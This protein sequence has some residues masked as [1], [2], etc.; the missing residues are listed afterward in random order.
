[1]AKS[2]LSNATRRG[3]APLE[4]VLWLPVLMFTAALIVN[5]GTA[6]AWR[7]RGETVS[8]NTVW[9]LRWPRTG[10]N[11]PRPEDHVWPE[12]ATMTWETDAPMT[13]LDDGQ[14]QHPVVRGPLPG[15]FEVK[16]TL[17]PD[18]RGAIK[19]VASIERPYAMLPRMGS[20]ESGRIE[21]PLLDQKWSVAQMGISTNE[22][23]RIPS[24]YVLPKAPSHY[25][26]AFLRALEAFAADANID[27]IRMLFR[28]AGGITIRANIYGIDPED[29]RKRKVERLVDH[30]DSRGDVQ[31][32]GISLTPRRLTG[33]FLSMLRAA[34][35]NGEMGLETAI[36]QL[37]DYR[38]RLPEIEAQL[39]QLFLQQSG[40]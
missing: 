21:H 24:L 11:E 23:R 34:Q 6:A 15:S 29:V 22:T 13:V 40:S 19:G 14:L 33:T 7:V 32:G 3:L 2:S 39:E 10:E 12:P 17:D 4:L 38:D 26:D 8:R 31:L 5:Y 16:P 9:R 27:A 30:F 25:A 35:Q 1:M 36:S 20:F 37:E 18:H 28:Y